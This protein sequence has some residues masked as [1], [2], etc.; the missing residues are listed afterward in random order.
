MGNSS[1]KNN[2][3]GGTLI[4]A[5][6]PP[7]DGANLPPLPKDERTFYVRVPEDARKGESFVVDIEGES[8]RVHPPKGVPPGGK[9]RY[10]H[11]A[12]IHHVYA[13]TLDSIPGMVVVQSKPIVWG[14]RAFACFNIAGVA[15]SSADIMQEAQAELLRQTVR[16][17][18]NA[19]LGI[20]ISVANSATAAGDYGQHK[21]GLVLVTATGTPCIVVKAGQ[22]APVQAT[23]TA[24]VTPLYNASVINTPACE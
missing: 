15:S 18:C 10:T 19:C 22:M 21:S 2:T 8:F 13:S 7:I 12:E 4:G 6:P 9:F 11:P 5:Y 14:S 17:G 23:S 16:S 24:V 1:S 20:N 3:K